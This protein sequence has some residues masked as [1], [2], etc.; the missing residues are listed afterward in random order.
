MTAIQQKA[1]VD[2]YGSL[3]PG[4]PQVYRLLRATRVELSTN[5][6]MRRVI[7]PGILEVES[8]APPET[9]GRLAGLI[10]GMDVWT[11]WIAYGKTGVYR[12]REAVLGESWDHSHRQ[13]NH[14]KFRVSKADYEN[15]R[16]LIQHGD[17]SGRWTK[18]QE[19]ILACPRR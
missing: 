2:L 14:K 16:M 18:E 9:E 13:S 17:G 15:R 3:S 6:R 11:N 12:Y 10:P 8:E 5:G 7:I 19:S 1:I 4:A